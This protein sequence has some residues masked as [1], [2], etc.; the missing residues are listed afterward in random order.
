VRVLVD[1]TYAE[2][3]WFSGTAVYLHELVAGLQELPGVEVVE[4]S[5]PQRRPRAGGGLGSLGNLLSDLRWTAAELPRIARRARAD[6]IHHPL[7]AHAPLTRGIAQVITVQDLAFER[8][9]ELFDAR[10][11]RYAQLA[12]RAAARRSGAVICISRTTAADVTGLWGVEPARVVVAPL[13]PGQPLSAPERERRHLLYVGDQEPRKN[14]S[15]L[16]EAYGIYREGSEEPLPLV[17]AGAAAARAPG[18][19]VE[20]HPDAEQLAGLYAGAVAL[21]HPSLY[22]GFGM[23][24]LEAMAAG[25]P[26]VA[27][28]SPG[29]TEVCG[30]AALYADPHDPGSLAAAITRIARDPQ[31]RGDLAD[32]GH[33]RAEL[34]SWRRCA[35]AHVDA[36]SL[37]REHG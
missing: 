31:L 18:I 22:E 26:V 24:P 34:F 3:A 36:Y 28:R 23:T 6:V 13:G 30:D 5:N 37:A 14:L 33:R 27:T 9:P 29:V 1:I 7:P 32:R 11:R 19:T 20:R 8:L 12:H 25:T 35:R 21:V 2:R 17:L 10:F 15:A 16:L 4:A